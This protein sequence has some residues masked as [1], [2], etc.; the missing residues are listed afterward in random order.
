MARPATRKNESTYS[1]EKVIRYLVALQPTDYRQ[2]EVIV[3][4]STPMANGLQK[5]RFGRSTIDAILARY[6]GIEI[7]PIFSWSEKNTE[8]YGL[9]L[10]KYYSIRF[11]GSIDAKTVAKSILQS[12]E[13]EYA[14]PR[15]ILRLHFHPNDSLYSYQWNLPQIHMEQA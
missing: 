11:T 1:H 2:S 13:V 7:K 12:E 14:E 10:S 8:S 15:P 3:K 4:L 9:D 6:P 5:S